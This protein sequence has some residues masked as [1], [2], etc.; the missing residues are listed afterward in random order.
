MQ[1]P[2]PLTGRFFRLVAAYPR[3]I[4]VVSLLL[5]LVSVLYTR[6]SMEY[7][8]GRDD[9]MPKNRQFFLNN[10]AY[11][12][13]FGGPDEIV[14][15]MESGDREQAT[16]F[17]E[18][19]E[20]LLRKEKG[21]FSDIFF[22]GGLPFFRKNGL[23]F[24]PLADIKALKKN[25]LMAQPVLKALSASPSVQTL[26]T[27]LTSEIDGWL[28]GDRSSPREQ[29]RLARITFM[30]EKLD[31]GFSS[32]GKGGLSNLSLEGFFLGSGSD[33]S[34]F[35]RAGRMQIL[36]VTP[37][38]KSGS[39]VPAEE[40]IATVR[41]VIES[42]KKLTEFKGVTVGLTGVPVLEHEE[43]ITS[44]KDITLAT[45]VSLI[46][47]VVLL[48]IAFR[49]LA[50]MLAAMISLGVA[51]CLSFGFATLAVGHLNILS[52]V[53]AIM[54][55]GIG[56]EYGIQVVLRY[57]EE[58]ALGMDEEAAIG[59]GLNR[60]IWAIVMAAAT[61]AA[62]FLTFVATD[63]KGISELGIIAGGGVAICVLVTFT[64]LP[65]L[66]VVMARR[67]A[68]RGTGR[69]ARGC[70]TPVASA[71]R[72]VSGRTLLFGY[73]KTVLL[74][75]AFLCL[76]SLYPVSR[77]G[78]DYNLM[79]LQAKGLESVT[80]A[81]KLM[82]SSEN[83]GYFAV[84]MANTKEEVRDKTKRLEAL[85][86]VDHV[87]SLLTFIPDQQKEKLAELAE[88]RRE[89][90]DVKPAPY[91]EDLKVMEL[92][93]VF[94]NF[95]NSVEKLTKLLAAEKR[96]ESKPAGKFLATLD[97][98]F[99]SLEKEKDTNAVG[100]LRDFQGGMFASLPQ[101]IGMLK[102]TL[103][104]AEVTEADI[105]QELRKRFVG[106]SGK[107]ALQIAPK[108]E[109][110]DREPLE[111]YLKGVRSVAPAAAGEPVMVY[112]SMTIMRDSYESAFLYAFIAIVAILLL[113][114]RS[115]VFALIGLVPLVVG[116]LFMVAGMWLCGISFNSANI[117]VLP[118]ILGIAVDSGIYIINRFRRE[119]ETAVEVVTRSTGLGV[120][121]NTLTI[122]ASFGA[123]MVAHHQGV[124]SIG[125]VMSLG[126]IACQF[127]FILVLPAILTL[128]GKR[129]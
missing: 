91:E 101:K 54:L 23:L 31:I 82:R 44:Q 125:A 90:G 87:V 102:E 106:K 115:V 55:I 24:M 51:I 42:L 60:N 113:A 5:A 14:V 73:P 22:P 40:A 29:E 104:A 10:A 2:P 48:L 70:S 128:V 34:A 15:V 112:E 43:M 33:D 105:P 122:M 27:Y 80:Y 123:L 39:F 12:R 4:I 62:A 77:I 45:V 124:F 108:K 59:Q 118:L 97:S 35:A 41:R 50:T 121:Y 84:T 129:R 53:F 127:A 69:G 63:F 19:L 58:L 1:T 13:E 64:V 89:L 93:T 38:E 79:N 56:I 126:M 32:F 36:T 111:A 7:L 8:T 75:T 52:M 65:A 81:Y 103:D 116:L 21:R 61:V 100:M 68:A 26:F 71:K 30:L 92:P 66:L 3:F 47:T 57:K 78:F 107:F 74:V 6:H 99:K 114:F 94:E 67:K 109:I 16:L 96:S 18:R 83:S 20:S 9:L 85:P 37:V 11:N 17:G 86:E 25:L 72:P 95:R 88:L 110:F 117:I 120:I 46:L 76:A 98:F 49:G 28:A 119:D